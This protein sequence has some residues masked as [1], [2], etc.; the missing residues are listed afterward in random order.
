VTVAA[1]ML[2]VEPDV[3][4]VVFRIRS[5]EA[6]P[7]VPCAVTVPPDCVKIRKNAAVPVASAEES[8]VIVFAVIR[9]PGFRSVAA[10]NEVADIVS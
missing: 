10:G 6:V 8:D 3:I 5:A 9:A 1:V 2:T 4:D 7:T